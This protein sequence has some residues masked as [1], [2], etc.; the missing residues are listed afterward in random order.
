M[1]YK[2]N[3]IKLQFNHNVTDSS[4]SKWEETGKSQFTRLQWPLS[5]PPFKN[6]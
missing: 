4:N 2:N 6:D 1:Q 5:V 3:N